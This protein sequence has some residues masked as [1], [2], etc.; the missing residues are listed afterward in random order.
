LGLFKKI[1]IV[2]NEIIT[3]TVVILC[4]ND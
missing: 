1:S 4:K 2:G 3:L